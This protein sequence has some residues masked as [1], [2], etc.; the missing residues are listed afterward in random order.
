MRFAPPQLTAVAWRI[1]LEFEALC[2]LYAPE[3]C[4]CEVFSAAY[5]LR[6]TSHGTHY[7]TPLSG[8]EKLIANMIDSNHG[9]RDSVIRVSGP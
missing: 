2:N 6:K 8:V 5:L 1:V 3:A 7:F 4:Q 9:M